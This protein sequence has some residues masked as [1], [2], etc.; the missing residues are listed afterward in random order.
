MI[1]I[2]ARTANKSRYIPKRLVSKVE[3]MEAEKVPVREI[4]EV[5]RTKNKR[6]K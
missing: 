2:G 4:L 1:K 3:K 6:K 5:L